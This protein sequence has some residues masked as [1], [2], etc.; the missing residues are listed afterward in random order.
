MERLYP[1][2]FLKSAGRWATP[3]WRPSCSPISLRALAFFSGLM[4]RVV[5]K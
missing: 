3:Y 5:V 4:E 1:S 2:F